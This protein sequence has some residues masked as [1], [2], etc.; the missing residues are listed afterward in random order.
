MAKRG[1]VRRLPYQ[2]QAAIAALHD[3]AARTEDTD[4]RQIRAL[5]DR[6]LAI[7]DG[8]TAR[9]SRAIASAMVDGPAAGLAELDDL[10]SDPVVARSHRLAGA[11]GHLLECIGNPLA[12]VDAYRDAANHTTSTAERNYLLLRAAH[13]ADAAALACR[14]E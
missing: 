12:A 7:A 10:S 11:R 5:Y 3:E 6:L 2:I 14:R 13:V 9:L 4:W 8:P 1:C